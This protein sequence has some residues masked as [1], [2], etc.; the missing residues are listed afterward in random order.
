MNPPDHWSGLRA[1]TDARIAIGRSGGSVPTKP[2]LDF[3]LAHA[4]ACDAVLSPFDPDELRRELMEIHPSVLSTESQASDRSIYLR[5]PDLGRLLRESSRSI[6]REAAGSEV[7]L[8]IVIS[9][10]L[11]A[12]ATMSQAA[13]TLRSL[14][15]MLVSSGW[16]LAPL[17]VV[18]HGRV[19]IQ[20]EVGSLLNA[21]MSLMLL[22]ERPGLGSPDSLGAYFTYNPV[23]GRTD[24]E[25]NCVS[26]I[27]A[28]GLPP[29]AAAAKLYSLLAA[30][31]RLGLSGI[32]L[33]DET[34]LPGGAL[35]MRLA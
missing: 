32:R 27:R 23:P 28:R 30:S 21:K 5:R 34:Q 29:E 31:L 15:P 26:N 6:L 12:I 11:S 22:G 8:A 18:K 25:R 4:R 1:F 33:K 10:G 16:R 7:D 24:S 2:H 20:D 13:P 14:V 35:K 3:R 19:A 9:D 17:V